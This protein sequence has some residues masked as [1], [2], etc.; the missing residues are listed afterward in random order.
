MTGKT[1]DDLDCGGDCGACMRAHEGH[2]WYVAEYSDL[3]P[4]GTVD[5]V[6]WSDDA[7]ENFLWE[8]SEGRSPDRAFE[9]THD[10]AGYPLT[11]TRHSIV[12]AMFDMNDLGLLTNERLQHFRKSK[13]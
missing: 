5:I 7:P 9:A 12:S 13:R 10:D 6:R 1:R 4:D 3:K 2:H 8:L 11:D